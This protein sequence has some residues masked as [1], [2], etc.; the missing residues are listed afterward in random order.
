MSTNPIPDD[1]QRWSA[2][3]RSALVL[4]ILKGETTPQEAARKHGLTVSEV[5][6]WRDKFLQGAENALRSKPRDEQ[7]QQGEYVRRLERKVGQLALDND[8]LKEA[9]KPYHPFVEGTSGE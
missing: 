1:L 3:R 2:K 5:E 8:I 6:S 4:S 7:G 9:M